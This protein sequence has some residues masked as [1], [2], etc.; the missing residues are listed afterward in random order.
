[1]IVP[2]PN[3]VGH[4]G[5]ILC[6][7]YYFYSN[8]EKSS[9]PYTIYKISYNSTDA[10]PKTNHYFPQNQVYM[11]AQTH[12]Q[13]LCKFVDEISLYPFDVFLLEILP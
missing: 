2:D 8:Y 1:M 6:F 13:A 5:D 10:S 12:L 3:P 9:T 4:S 11:F 7:R